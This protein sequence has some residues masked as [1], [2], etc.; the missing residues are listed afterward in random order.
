[1]PARPEHRRVPRRATAEA[2]RGRVVVVVG[3]D[4]DDRTADPVDE[5]RDPDQLRSDVVHAAREE[6]AAELHAG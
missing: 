2:V 1:M 3:L 4:L 6:V 5:Q